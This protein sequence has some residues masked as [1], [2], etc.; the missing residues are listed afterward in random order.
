MELIGGFEEEQLENVVVMLR[1]IKNIIAEAADDAY[2]LRLANDY[3][4]DTDADKGAL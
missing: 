3:E 1:S 4:N 2:C